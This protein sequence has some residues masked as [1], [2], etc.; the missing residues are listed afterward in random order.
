[1]AQLECGLSASQEHAKTLNFQALRTGLVEEGS[2]PPIK[3][4]KAKSSPFQL[5]LGN[6]DN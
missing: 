4:T 6:G 1:M 3:S 5:V 2:K